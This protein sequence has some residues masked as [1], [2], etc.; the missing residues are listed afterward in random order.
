MN[1]WAFAKLT[2]LSLGKPPGG[3]KR[4]CQIIYGPQNFTT[5]PEVICTMTIKRARAAAQ[6][7]KKLRVWALY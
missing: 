3:V 2:S 1:E 7:N 5:G 6:K 4:G